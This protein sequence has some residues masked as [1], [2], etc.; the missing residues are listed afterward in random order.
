MRKS[1]LLTLV[2]AV[3]VQAPAFG[4]AAQQAADDRDK[5]FR[6]DLL[7]KL[8]GDWKLTRNMQAQSSDHLA[9]A[10]WILNHQFLQVHMK[11]GGESQNYEAIVMIG[12]DELSERYVAH[13]ID[14]FGGRVSETLG[15]GTRTGNSIRFV[16]EYP[17]GPFVNTFTWKPETKTWTSLMITKDKNGSWKTF[18]EDTYH[19]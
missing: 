14:I 3:C 1:L 2:F 5:I 10:G 4:V 19:H 12:Y 13:W 9:T 7:E 15:Y 11:G 6:D 18:A 16:F 8:V 17:E